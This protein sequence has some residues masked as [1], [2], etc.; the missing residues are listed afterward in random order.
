MVLELSPA[1]MELTAKTLA[2]VTRVD[3]NR[4]RINIAAHG[5][6]RPTVN[7]HVKLMPGYF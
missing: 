5:I 7:P 4:D 1:R 6:I 2:I 3:S